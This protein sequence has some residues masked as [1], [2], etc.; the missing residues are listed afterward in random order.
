MQIYFPHVDNQPAVVLKLVFKDQ[1]AEVVRLVK[2]HRM[3][4]C[5]F[6]FVCL[7]AADILEVHLKVD[8]HLL[9]FMGFKPTEVPPPPSPPPPSD[10]KIDHPHERHVSSHLPRPQL[11]LPHLSLRF[12]SLRARRRLQSYPPPS[13]LLCPELLIL[14]PPPPA[15]IRFT[16]PPLTSRLIPPP[17]FSL[18]R[19]EP[20]FL[21]EPAIKP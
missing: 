10:L 7:S 11:P 5:T 2:S 14:R 1:V 20:P 15:V 12:A 18:R 16:I 19:D 6:E 21:R 13:R 4:K 8:E 3:S 17:P 9:P